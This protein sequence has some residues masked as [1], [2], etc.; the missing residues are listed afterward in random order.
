M[1]ITSPSQSLQGPGGKDSRGV[2]RVVVI[3]PWPSGEAF[4]NRTRDTT[5]QRARCPAARP[6]A[7]FPLPAL[8][9]PSAGVWCCLDC[10]DTGHRQFLS[11]AALLRRTSGRHGPID[12]VRA[13][14]RPDGKYIPTSV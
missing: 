9:V 11:N 13:Q 6:H 2:H 4:S 3:T 1:A 5:V 10:S 14:V 7:L 8:D 12:E